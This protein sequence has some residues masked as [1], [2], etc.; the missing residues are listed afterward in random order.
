MTDLPL[1][2]DAPKTCGKYS[3]PARWGGVLGPCKLT[4]GHDGWHSAAD[5][6]AWDPATDRQEATL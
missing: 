4:P 6:S 2:S 1:E 3:R 5:G